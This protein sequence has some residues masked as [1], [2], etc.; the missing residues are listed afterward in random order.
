MASVPTF[1]V[2]ED[3]YSAIERLAETKTEFH[4][5]QMFAMSGKMM[6]ADAVAAYPDKQLEQPQ[7]QPLT[8]RGELIGFRRYEFTSQVAARSK[9]HSM[10]VASCGVTSLSGICCIG[11]CPCT[12]SHLFCAIFFRYSGYNVSG[13]PIAA[14]RGTPN[15]VV[16]SSTKGFFSGK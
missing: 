5:G 14:S 10:T 13:F 2:T 6:L 15:L 9:S 3:E 12:S 1:P 4:D 11:G 7:A 16:I 8:T